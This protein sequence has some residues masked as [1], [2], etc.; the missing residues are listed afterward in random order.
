MIT[1][2]TFGTITV[3]NQ[4]YNSDIKIVNG[5]VVPDWWRDSG[6]RVDVGD[7][8]DILQ[9]KPDIIVIGK[10]D[11]GYMKVADGLRDYAGNHGIELIAEQTPTAIQTFNRLFKEGRNVAAGFHV[12][13]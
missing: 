5:E 4:R 12:G 3:G 6:H 11:P 9:N 2:F 8:L 13:C 10:G 7:I 1:K